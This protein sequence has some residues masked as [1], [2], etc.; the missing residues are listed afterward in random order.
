MARAKGAWIVT[1]IAT[2]LLV[3]AGCVAAAFAASGESDTN[4]PVPRFVSLHSDKVNLRAGPGDRYP[5]EWVLTRKEMPVEITG[6]LEHWR[7]IRDWEGTTGWVHERMLTGKRAV[8]V[9]GGVRPLLQQPD[10]AAAVIAR[11]EPGVIGRL[12]ECRGIW[13]KIE[14]SEATGW[15]R[16]SDVWG[17]YPDETVP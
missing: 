3:F 8:I 9:R 1:A 12:V 16:R 13:C 6:Q 11:A 2:A 17:V 14:T 7:R 15:M 5:I 4:L 10:P